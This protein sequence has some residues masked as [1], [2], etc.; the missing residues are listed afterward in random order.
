MACYV[1]APRRGTKPAEI[2]CDW[3]TLLEPIP[4]LHLRAGNPRRAVVDASAESLDAVRR[5]LGSDFRIEPMIEH[6]TGTGC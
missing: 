3:A 5:L 1:I 4:G 2:G 6:R